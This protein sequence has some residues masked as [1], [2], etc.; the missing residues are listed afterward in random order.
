MLSEHESEN[1]SRCAHLVFIQQPKIQTAWFLL[2]WGNLKKH[3]RL[4]KRL[5]VSAAKCFGVILVKV[6]YNIH[7]TALTCQ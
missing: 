4:L 5:M 6:V 1:E 2:L 3:L 7:R